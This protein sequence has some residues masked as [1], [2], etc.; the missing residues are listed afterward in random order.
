MYDR[1][2]EHILKNGS[3]DQAHKG[4]SFNGDPMEI[5]ESFFG[6]VNPF[7]IA[8]DNKGQQVP[9]IQKIESDLHKDYVTDES[10][11]EADLVLNVQCTLKEFFYGA[12]KRI[13]YTRQNAKAGKASQNESLVAEQ[14]VTRVT[15][16]I[17]IKPGMREGM[18]MR[19]PDEGNQTDLK[20]VG[21]L[22]IHLHKT[23][24]EKM[25]R[26]GDNLIYHHKISLRDALC[27]APVEFAT[28]DDEIIK[29]AADEVI[30]PQ[31]TKVFYGKGMPVYNDNPLS[32][33]MHNHSRGN[34]ILKFTIEMPNSFTDEKRNALV[35][36]LCQ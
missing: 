34:L 30:S 31:T 15:K 7:H 36:I 13:K 29:F 21:D 5:F 16:D 9:M 23:D 32:A 3:P 1:Y 4:Y 18:T 20:R 19:F 6:T 24:G 10:I 35:D 26:V 8:L 27:S 25:T 33:L 17:F 2:G 11:K 14:N 28:L 22:V 12:T